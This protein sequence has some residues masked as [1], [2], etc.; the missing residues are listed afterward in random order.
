VLEMDGKLDNLDEMVYLESHLCTI[1][2]YIVISA[3]FTSD[4]GHFPSI[5]ATQAPST[6]ASSPSRSNA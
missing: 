6:T 3:S 2:I 5:G 1:T 4:G